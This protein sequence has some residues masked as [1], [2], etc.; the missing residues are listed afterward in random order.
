MKP[1]KVARVL[2][3]LAVAFAVLCG[4]GIFMFAS[5]V[6]WAGQET[7]IKEDADR[8]LRVLTYWLTAFGPAT[9]IM[10]LAG[11]FLARHST[12][13]SM[14]IRLWIG[15][16]LGAAASFVAAAIRLL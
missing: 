2:S 16:V 3:Y 14:K 10:G 12:R 15:I 4:I 5:V 8:A 1:K 7:T 13:Q 11:L 9:F 6:N